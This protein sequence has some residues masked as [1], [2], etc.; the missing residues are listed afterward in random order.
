[1]NGVL[2]VKEREGV[3]CRKTCHT[4]KSSTA[5]SFE[6][7]LISLWSERMRPGLEVTGDSLRQTGR[8]HPGELGNSRADHYL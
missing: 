3:V 7:G 6:V 8:T 5:A 2:W 4:Q 1:M